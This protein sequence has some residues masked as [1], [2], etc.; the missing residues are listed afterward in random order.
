MLKLFIILTRSKLIYCIQYSIFDLFNV[1]IKV[2]S[3]V[4]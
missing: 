2:L 4:Y 3:P 1:F